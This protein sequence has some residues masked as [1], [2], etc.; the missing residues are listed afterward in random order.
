MTPAIKQADPALVGLGR[1]SS[2]V[3]V[4]SNITRMRSASD[5]ISSSSTETSSTALPR[6]AHRDQAPVDEL[7]RADVDA[8]GRL[9]DQQ[10][11]RVVLHLARQHQLLLVAA[12][13][14]VPP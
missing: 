10:Q 1:A 14:R 3:I 4:P 9:A 7:D 5:M 2:P 6:V 11:I 12:G 13:E 8:A